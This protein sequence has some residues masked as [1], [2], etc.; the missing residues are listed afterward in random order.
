MVAAP[1]GL[2]S[3]NSSRDLSKD[4]GCDEGKTGYC[5]ASL[6]SKA[7]ARELCDCGHYLELD[8]CGRGAWP[9]VGLVVA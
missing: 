1:S 4:L 8:E 7:K 2:G 6:T 5:S 3:C 9:R